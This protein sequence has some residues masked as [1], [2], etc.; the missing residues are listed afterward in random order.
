MTA[1]WLRLELRRRWR[2]L[3]LLALL[4]AFAAATVLAAVAGARRGDSALDRLSER[5]LPATVEVRPGDPA[6][7]WDVVRGLPGVE[8]VA[9]VVE[10]TWRIDGLPP[11]SEAFESPADGEFLHSIDRAVALD[12]RLPDPARPDEA[13]VTPAFARTHGL[14][15]GDG[16]TL[17]LPD[18]TPVPTRIVGV[19]RTPL[20][21]DSPQQPGLLMPSAGLFAAHPD[22]FAGPDGRIVVNALVR[23]AP[24][25][26]EAAFVA[27]LAAA[28]G[29]DDLTIW[30]HAQS[31]AYIDRITGIESTALLVFAGTAGV[32]AVALVGQALGRYAATTAADLRVVAALG[33]TPAQARRAAAAAPGLAAVAG[34]VLGVAAAAA[35][36]RWFPY[37]FAAHLE[38]A[39]GADLDPL[40]LGAGMVVVPSLAV[41]GTLAAARRV[42][43]GP[44]GTG[45]R[46][47]APGPARRRSA[48]VTV[49]ARHG[50]PVPAVVGARYA[51]EPGRGPSAVPVRPALAG[52][53]VGVLGV[54]A[55]AT[56]SAAV[57]DATTNPARYG[58]VHDLEAPLAGADPGAGDVLAAIAADPGVVAVNDSRAGVGTAAGESVTVFSLDPVAGRFEP[59]VLAG[60]LPER[61]GEIALAPYTADALGAEPGDTIELAGTRAT[62]ELTV[63]GLTLLPESA[64]NYYNI[65]AWVGAAGYDRLFGGAAA[66]TAHIVVRP[67]ADAAAVAERLSAA[68]PPAADGGP[69]VRPRLERDSSPELRQLQTLPVFLAVFLGVLAVG[70]VGHALASAV[71]RRRHD[72]AVLRAVGMTR[73][74]C[75]AVVLTQASVV[76]AAGL[77]LGVPLG[78]ALGRTVWRHVADVTTVHYVPPDATLLLVLAV[79]VTVLVA[80]LLAAWPSQR[81]A[82]MR[83]G[84]VLRAE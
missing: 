73:S 4:V 52:A 15:A 53:V 30:P 36:S 9:L 49:A 74:Q 14:G 51:L 33:L 77:L 35:A 83:V 56:F 63:T 79:P 76:A 41:A 29:R 70:A 31:W 54:L 66:R 27:D 16:V 18:G 38:P 22:A 62:R 80:N 8:A 23:L 72:L 26:P 60:R 28:T 39:P 48:V 10:S 43:S 47:G 57:A 11:G 81:A 65:G 5:T 67:G 20:L 13:V 1:S 17:R 7:D 42:W 55:A 19:V 25:R 61:D 40:V 68:L 46:A 34:T 32:A 78:V 24:D 84:S 75:R 59:V 64:E 6:F 58:Q 3:L 71:R 82:S 69:A 2:S 45:A 12:G 50:L 37:G 21:A 44:A